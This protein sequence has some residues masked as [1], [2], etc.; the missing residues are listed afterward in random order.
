MSALEIAGL[1][2]LVTMATTILFLLRRGGSTRA[3]ADL[4]ELWKVAFDSSPIA[5]L[6]RQNGVYVHCNDACIRILGARDK[7]HVLEG[8]P[9]KVV[10]ERQPNGRLMADI[11]KE[12][13]ES[14]QQGKG[15][16]YQGLAGHTL[17]THK[18]LHVDMYWVPTR[19]RSEPAVLSYLVDSSERI[20]IADE[21]RQQTQQTARNFE[22]TI[23][24][25]VQSLASTAAEMR[26]F[27]NDMS[28]TVKD[29]SA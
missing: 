5:M 10:S 14:L 27:F 15:F 23:G 28:T 7:S 22:T 11:F 3:D 24:G 25:L 1:V 12:C 17:D 20:R 2:A 19:F 16:Q 4:V 18:P 6:I 13:A 26:S 8:G 9:T 21:A 29:A